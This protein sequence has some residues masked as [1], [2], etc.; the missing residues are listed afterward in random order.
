MKSCLPFSLAGTSLAQCPATVIVD[1]RHGF[2]VGIFNYCDRWCDACEFTSRCRLFADKVEIEASADP[3]L[4]ALVE[5]PPLEPPPPPPPWLA[6]L[7]HEMDDAIGKQET[8]SEPFERPIPP[9]H[10]IIEARAHDY[11]MRVYQWFQERGLAPPHDPADPEEIILWFHTLMPAKIHRALHGLAN[12]SPEDRD[13]PADYDG[14]AKIALLGIDRSHA[15]WRALVDRCVATDADAARFIADLVWLG[16][17]LERVFP[18]ARAFVRPGF[19][20]P[21]EVAKLL[22]QERRG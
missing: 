5:A 7:L 3:G 13:W 8:D 14:S 10:L 15:A 19:D 17:A 9:E 2:I 16:E 21:D 1:V 22:A 18:N 4:R 12:D 11:C 6:E 20:E